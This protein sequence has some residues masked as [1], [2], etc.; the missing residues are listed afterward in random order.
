MLV[1]DNVRYEWDIEKN[2][3]NLEKH[4][5]DFSKVENFEW[6]TAVERRSDR[7][8]EPR[9]VAIGYL[10][11]R[12]HVVVFTDRGET[13]RIISLREASNKERR[14]YAQAQTGR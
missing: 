11:E 14:E 5:I 4:K 7:F 2:R 10:G 8:Q 12:L 9:W 13:R 3:V 6:N 1:R